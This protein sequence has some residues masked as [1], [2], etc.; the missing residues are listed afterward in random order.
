MRGTS[1]SLKAEEDSCLVNVLSGEVDFLDTRKR[2]KFV[3]ANERAWSD[4]KELVLERKISPKDRE[5]IEAMEAKAKEAIK[6]VPISSLREYFDLVNPSLGMC[7][8]EEKNKRFLAAGGD[9]RITNSIN[10]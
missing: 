1:F 8:P 2:S 6:G 5:R 9:A 3:R 7:D 4:G 10:C